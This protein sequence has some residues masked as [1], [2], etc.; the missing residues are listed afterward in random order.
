MLWNLDHGINIIPHGLLLM[1]CYGSCY[2]FVKHSLHWLY[3]LF[4]LCILGIGILKE[5]LLHFVRVLA[6]EIT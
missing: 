5:S 4:H 2:V 6:L 1:L 3:H